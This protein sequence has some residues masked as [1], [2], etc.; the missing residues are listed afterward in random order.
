MCPNFG[1][2]KYGPLGDIIILGKI[3]ISEFYFF[4]WIKV[5]LCFNS[6]KKRKNQN[7][8]LFKVG[9]IHKF[10]GMHDSLRI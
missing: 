5:N 7:L 4:S 6:L 3:A 8:V 9:E 1:L 2:G 10:C